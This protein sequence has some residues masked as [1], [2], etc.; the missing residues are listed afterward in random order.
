MS[1]AWAISFSFEFRLR[2]SLNV[3]GHLTL[4]SRIR[5]VDGKPFSFSIAFHTYFSI[6]DIRYGKFLV[7]MGLVS[8]VII[9][10]ESWAISP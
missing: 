3:D 1:M 10:C 8:L 7:Q 9:S 2:V 4:I 6:S 5:N